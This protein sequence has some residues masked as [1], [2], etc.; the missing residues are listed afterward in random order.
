MDAQDVIGQPLGRFFADTGQF[1]E[2]ID[3]SRDGLREF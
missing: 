2:F 1:G 3:Q